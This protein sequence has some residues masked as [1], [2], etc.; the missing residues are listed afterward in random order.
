M[1]GEV[2][3][4]AG[5]WY[6]A[7]N[8]KATDHRPCVAALKGATQSRHRRVTTHLVVAEA[9]ALLLSRVHRRAALEFLR[10]VQLPPTIVV[11][12]TTELE[13]R[14]VTDWI[15]RYDDQRFSFADAVSF[16]VMSERGITDALARDRHFATAG[17]TMVPIRR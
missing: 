5:V 16:A 3:V 6:A 9:H 7:L 11:E 14:A 13:Q 2:F 12:S 4:D 17:F 1:A 15:E 10:A 8:P